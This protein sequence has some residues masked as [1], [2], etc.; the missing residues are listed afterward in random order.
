MASIHQE[1]HHYIQ[2]RKKLTG[3]FS[4][5]PRLPA[6]IQDTY[7]A[8][9]LLSLLGKK[10]GVTIPSD[11][12]LLDYLTNTAHAERHNAKTTFQRLACCR[13]VGAEVSRR[14]ILD[15]VRRRLAETN[16]LDERYYCCR[17]IRELADLEDDLAF[18][19]G[20]PPAVDWSFRT[21]SELWMLLFLAKRKPEQ[22]YAL[23]VWLQDCQTG[24]GG[25]GFLPATTAFLENCYDCL[26]ALHWLGSPP[27]YPQ[28]CRDFVLACRTNNG[29]FARC[30]GAV[31]FLSSSWQAVATL[32]LLANDCSGRG[33]GQG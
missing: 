1:L 28:A 33:R 7:H 15:F 24:D 3:G 18:N 22:H 29:G 30:H 19:W 16:V 14:A 2:K 23:T 31:A 12:P 10:G 11:G 6:T 9:R 21:A 8:L 25:F 17:L 26:R 20:L 13:M 4:A 27:R 32:E 5:T